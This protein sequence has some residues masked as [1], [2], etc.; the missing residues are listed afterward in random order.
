MPQKSN[1]K[2]V[3]IIPARFKSSRLPGKPLVEICGQSLVSRVWDICSKVFPAEDIYVATDDKRISKHCHSHGIQTLMTSPKCLTGTDRVVAASKQVAA[4]I[5]INVQGDEPLLDPKDIL[6][7]ISASKKRPKQV[8]SAMCQIDCEAEFRSKTVPKVVFR[9]DGRLLYVSRAG[10]PTTKSLDFQKAYKQ[11]CI[12]A[13]PRECLDKYFN[14]NRKTPLE[15]IEDCELLR[16]LELGYEVY[17]IEVSASSVAVDVPE[18]VARVEALIS[19][20]N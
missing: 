14:F 18:D 20:L 13:L 8:I 7:V 17:L 11:V 10:I 2:F 1:L 6:K 19:A 15:S 12:Y 16:F 3:L 9:P 5:Y 4:D